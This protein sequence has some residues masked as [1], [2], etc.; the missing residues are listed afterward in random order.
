MLFVF[1]AGSVYMTVSS[2]YDLGKKSGKEQ[3]EIEHIKQ[4]ELE[5]KQKT[6]SINHQNK[7]NYE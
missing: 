7:F 1:G 2:I 6:D 3:M 5:Y 4:L